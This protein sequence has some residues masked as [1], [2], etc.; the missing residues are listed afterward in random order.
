M[1]NTEQFKTEQFGAEHFF[2]SCHPEKAAGG[3]FNRKIQAGQL[4]V[5]RGGN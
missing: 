5:R 3:R 1:F 4:E 2:L